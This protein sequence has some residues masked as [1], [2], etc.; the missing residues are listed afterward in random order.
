MDESFRE[1]LVDLFDPI[2]GVSFRRMFGGLGIFRE[3]L[4]F[5]L[6]AQDI[7]Y[8]KTDDKTRA[9]FEVEE[10]G[11]FVYQAKDGPRSTSYWR[12]PERL[13]D[14]PEEF[15]GWAMTASPWRK[16]LRRKRRAGWRRS[17]GRGRVRTL[18]AAG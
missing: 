2:D 12:A 14:E 10:C 17:E 7:L 11:P 8:F 16:G 1:F 15:R 9:G 18:S 5:A 3:G 6:V 4:M 13:F